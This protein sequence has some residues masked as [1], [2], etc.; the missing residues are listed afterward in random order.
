VQIGDENVHRVRSVAEEVFGKDQFV[1]QIQIKKSGGATSQ[2]LAGV[3]DFVLWYAK[4]IDRLKYRSVF[5]ARD[6]EGK[7]GGYN[8]LATLDS[9]WRPATDVELKLGLK[10]EAGRLMQ[11]ITLT[12]LPYSPV[13]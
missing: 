12:S 2:Y 11:L 4:R 7:G 3:T 5:S 9:H 10:N 6:S 8:L 1:A 13:P